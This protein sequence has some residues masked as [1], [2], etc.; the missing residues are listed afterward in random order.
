MSASRDVGTAL[1][2]PEVRR[3]ELGRQFD[4]QPSLFIPVSL[5][6]FVLVVSTSQMNYNSS[7]VKFVVSTSLM[8]TIQVF[9]GVTFGRF[10]GT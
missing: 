9:M 1:P 5:A 7:F 3:E 2:A 8:L 6:L 10:V 4:R